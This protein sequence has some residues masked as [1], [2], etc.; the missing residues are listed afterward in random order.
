MFRKKIE[1]AK[2]K[3]ELK[4][5]GKHLL[6]L[7]KFN[8]EDSRQAALKIIEEHQNDTDV[9]N[10]QQKG[11]ATPL[12]LAC[13]L[14]TN[15]IAKR[16]LAT[17]C[18]DVNAKGH[19]RTHALE[20]ALIAKNEKIALLL[21]S[22]RRVLINEAGREGVPPIYLAFNVNKIKF[23]EDCQIEIVQAMLGRTDLAASCRYVYEGMQYITGYKTYMYEC[24]TLLHMMVEALRLF[25]DRAQGP[26]ERNKLYQHKFDVTLQLLKDVLASDQVDLNAFAINVQHTTKTKKTALMLA[27]ESGLSDVV[28]ILLAAG[29]N[30][31]L[32]DEGG[33]SARQL[34][35]LISVKHHGTSRGTNAAKMVEMIE[36]VKRNVSVAASPAAMFAQV[37]AEYLVPPQ[38]SA[39]PQEDVMAKPAI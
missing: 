14:K 27:V 26:T 12:I 10:Y 25:K 15:K 38:P 29:A 20:A 6:E 31:N 39:P 2:H 5:I 3:S 19:K 21:A 37:P 32:R 24:K 9:I 11:G 4:R 34:A 1:E 13:E 35:K 16:L 28:D 36:K 23:S 7:I 33:H 8:D 18:V 30:V 17:S 22:D